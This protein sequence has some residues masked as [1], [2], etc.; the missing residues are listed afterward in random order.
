MSGNNGTPPVETGF[1]E[2]NG[3]NVYYERTGEGH[4][5]VLVH[6]GLLD[7]RMWDDQFHA[8]A[9]RYHVIRYD[10]RG[11]GSTKMLKED[12]THHGDLIGLLDGLDIDRH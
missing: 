2:A 12:F 1:V 11:S 7:R 3:I 10:I 4:P 9:Q 5:L 8:F 6:R